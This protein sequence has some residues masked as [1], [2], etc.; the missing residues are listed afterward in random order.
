[1]QG[2]VFVNVRLPAMW[3]PSEGEEVEM[4]SAIGC[5]GGQCSVLHT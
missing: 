2:A 5:L 1:M 4:S 3:V